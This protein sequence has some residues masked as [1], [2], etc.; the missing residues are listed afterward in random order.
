MTASV[1]KQ[2]R[3]RMVAVL[4]NATD[5]VD[6]VYDSRAAAFAREETPCIAILAPDTEDTQ[7]FSDD[8]DRNSA[9]IT[10]EVL[11]RD[12]EWRDVADGI[13]VVAHRILM[14]DP[15]LRSMVTKLSKESRRWENEDADQTAGVDS[16]TYRAVYLTASDDLTVT[17]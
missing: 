14:R 11:V 13:M 9:Q 10:V 5:A 1:C 8:T 17:Y 12:D 15:V 7:S 16:V 2:I 6:R 3:D 4:L